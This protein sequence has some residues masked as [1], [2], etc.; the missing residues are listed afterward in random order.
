[1][2]KLTTCAQLT[3]QEVQIDLCQVA[4]DFLIS[5]VVFDAYFCRNPT[6]NLRT[7][8]FIWSG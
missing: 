5:V 6:P 4:L 8:V 1:M 2:P 7:L 3:G